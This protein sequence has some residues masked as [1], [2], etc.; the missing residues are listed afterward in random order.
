MGTAA[1]LLTV[2]Q[3]TRGILDKLD[4]LSVEDA[5]KFLEVFVEDLDAEKMPG[6]CKGGEISW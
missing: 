1:A 3:S 6:W 2:E 4:K 5:G